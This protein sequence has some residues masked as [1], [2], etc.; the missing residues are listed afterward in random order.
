MGVLD[1][2]DG[3]VGPEGLGDGLAA[4]GAQLVGVEAEIQPH[5]E[6][7]SK[8]RSNSITPRHNEARNQAYTDLLYVGDRPVDL[9]GLADRFA[10]LRTH[11]VAPEAAK[12]RP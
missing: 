2:L 5:D 9:E 6:V 4:L 7:S 10:G 3:L 11:P 8:Y 12:R 1:G